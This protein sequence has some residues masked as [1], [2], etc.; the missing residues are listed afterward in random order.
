MYHASLRGSALERVQYLCKFAR[1]CDYNDA[2]YCAIK[3]VTAFDLHFI[4]TCT[5]TNAHTRTYT[6]SYANT[7][8]RRP[9]EREGEGQRER[10][11]EERDARTKTRTHILSLTHTHI[12]T[13]THTDTSTHRSV[14]GAEI[15]CVEGIV[16]LGKKRHVSKSAEIP[17]RIPIHTYKIR[18]A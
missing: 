14:L 1:M 11:G 5:H 18:G 7:Q 6:H 8:I 13:H 2:H 10:R 9:R 12:H 15:V 16:S 4:H 3:T 17:F